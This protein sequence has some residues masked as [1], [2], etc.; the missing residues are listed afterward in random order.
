MVLWLQDYDG[1]YD[2]MQEKKAE[3]A[4]VQHH[5][6]HRNL[7]AREI[8]EKIILLNAKF[9]T[10]NAKSV[11]LNAKFIVAGAQEEGEQPGA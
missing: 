6:P 4:Q 9:I 2:E 5:T 3:S 10:L 11:I 1:V 8:S 7:I